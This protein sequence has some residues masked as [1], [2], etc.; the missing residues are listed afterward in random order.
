[1]DDW[2]PARY[3]QCDLCQ[4]QYTRAHRYSALKFHYLNDL[5]RTISHFPNVSSSDSGATPFPRDSSDLISAAA[6]LI[7]RGRISLTLHAN[8]IVRQAFYSNANDINIERDHC[9]IQA[10]PRRSAALSV[11]LKERREEIHEEINPRE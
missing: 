1:M 8:A 9:A 2:N 11:S 7:K 10:P 6:F 3:S 5:C 4:R